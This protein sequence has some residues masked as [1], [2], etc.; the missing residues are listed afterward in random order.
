[1]D[2]PSLSIE[3]QIYII[4]FN[5]SS[6]GCFRAQESYDFAKKMKTKTSFTNTFFTVG[7]LP[8]YWNIAEFFFLQMD[9]LNF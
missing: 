7:D 5:A 1:M 6:S 4:L 2:G 9:R 3:L 8:V